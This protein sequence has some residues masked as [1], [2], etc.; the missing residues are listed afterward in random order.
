MEAV[1]KGKTL[2]KMDLSKV[3]STGE[4]RASDS[5]YYFVYVDLSGDREINHI[6]IDSTDLE[7]TFDKGHVYVMGIFRETDEGILPVGL[8]TDES[9]ELSSIPITYDATS[10]IDLGTLVASG[11]VLVSTVTLEDFSHLLGNISEEALKQFA[12]YDITLKN[13][14][15]P[16]IDRNGI[17]DNEEGIYWGEV[18]PNNFK[19]PSEEDFYNPKSPEDYH[20]DSAVVLWINYKNH[21]LETDL[22]TITA[23]A[24]LVLPNGETVIPHNSADLRNGF[25]Q[26]YFN[27]Q[28]IGKGVFFFPSGEYK[29]IL[30][31]KDDGRD[32]T[33][34][35]NWA[36]YNPS[37]TDEGMIFPTFLV[38]AYSDGIAKSISMKF[39]LISNSKKQELEDLSLL[40]MMVKSISFDAWDDVSGYA[41]DIDVNYDDPKQEITMPENAFILRTP[42]FEFAHVHYVDIS[43][44]DMGFTGPIVYENKPYGYAD[45]S[46]NVM[47]SP[48]SLVGI[49]YNHGFIRDDSHF[50][51]L[52]FQ[53]D[54][55]LEAFNSWEGVLWSRLYPTKV[56]SYKLDG[57]NITVNDGET[58]MTCTI[59]EA[60][61][62]DG[63][64][65]TKLE[66]G[67][68][69]LVY[70]NFY[71]YINAYG[72]KLE[73]NGYDYLR[74]KSVTIDSF[75]NNVLH[76]S[77]DWDGEYEGGIVGFDFYIGNSPDNMKLVYFQYEDYEHMKDRRFSMDLSEFE[78][79]IY[80]VKIVAN[81]WKEIVESN[82]VEIEVK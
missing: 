68:E 22:Y 73:N 70:T 4:N 28:Y 51:V 44:N 17:F 23:C 15:N 25:Y 2:I 7:L 82:V 14:M 38:K 20:T 53:P 21:H 34:Y 35:F 3:L 42:G 31:D 40:K 61:V 80:Y 27:P 26:F 6:L 8:I 45:L 37:E 81:A 52:V 69:T 64:R 54:G 79:G 71:S 11:N 76:W 62:E 72:K 33:L 56:F 16:D 48:S 75:E 50:A 5:N 13:F 47:D 36:F 10:T 59:K 41:V 46:W 39:W 29:V 74:L 55:T 18:T 77:I 78:P 65:F 32:I 1:P 9:G 12:G 43:Q 58:S 66:C 63:R 60:Q 24:T 57:S 19:I 49:W 67:D 30:H